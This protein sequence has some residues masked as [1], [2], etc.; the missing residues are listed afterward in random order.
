MNKRMKQ[1][2]ARSVGSANGRRR[3]GNSFSRIAVGNGSWLLHSTNPGVFV[4]PSVDD[5]DK[6]YV[7]VISGKV[8][9]HKPTFA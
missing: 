9:D 3:K 5:T 8:S 6:E 4:G 1:G 7:K 2:S